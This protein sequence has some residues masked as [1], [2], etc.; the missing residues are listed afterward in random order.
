M[1][2]QKHQPLE[3]SRS[4]RPDELVLPPNRSFGLLFCLV[5]AIVAAWPLFFSG[6]V[7]LWAVIASGLFG[8]VSLVAPDILTPLNRAWMKF[9]ALLHRIVSPVVLGV[10]F[11][12]VITPFGLV[13]RLFR[14][15]LL[16]L[17][18][19]ATDSYWVNREPPGPKPDSLTNQF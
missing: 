16:G 5:F 17:R 18:R 19:E 15:N 2:T 13:M 6:S 12:V 7:R 8:A 10:L 14:R 3:S 1:A 11:F 9:G 4:I